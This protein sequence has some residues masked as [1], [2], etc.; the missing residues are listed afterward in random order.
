MFEIADLDISRSRRYIADGI[1]VLITR[2]GYVLYP[3]GGDKLKA[4]EIQYK[5]LGVGV[6]EIPKE[7]Y[8]RLKEEILSEEE[9]EPEVETPEGELDD[10]GIAVFLRS[11]LEEAVSEEASDIHIL[12]REKSYEIKFRINGILFSRRKVS[13]PVGERLVNKVKTVANMDIANSLIPQDSKFS[14][15][16][17]GQDVEVRVSTS[18]TVLGER[19]VL[20]IQRKTNVLAY[21]FEDLGLG[22]KILEEYLEDLHKP[23]GMILN[24]GPTGQGKTT[25]FYV[26]IVH[27]LKAFGESRSVVTIEDPV[28]IRIPGIDQIEVD[29]GVGRTF[30]G[31][32]RSLLRQDPDVILVGE[33]RDEETA[34]LAVRASMTGHLVLATLH[35]IDSVNAIP[36][37]KDLGI[38]SINLAS[39]LNGV[40]SQRLVRK[41]CRNC[42]REVPVPKQ[43]REKYSIP[44]DVYLKGEGCEECGYTG[45]K[46][47]TAVFEYLKVDEE[48]KWMISEG[49]SEL[50]IR[51]RLRK[52]DFLSLWDNALLLVRK[53]VTSLEEVLTEIPRFGTSRVFSLSVREFFYPKKKVPVLVGNWKGY[54]F[55]RASGGISVIF[56]EPVPLE[57][58]REIPLKLEGKTYTF[59]PT[60][61]GYFDGKLLVG[62]RLK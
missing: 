11:L 62:G 36:R 55:D 30:S 2:D 7:D 8:E 19:A 41:V 50:E 29:E 52:R 49:F 35:A 9:P 40:L 58:F 48:V 21:S 43:I 31:V 38:S 10:T 51:E 32:L 24:V 37:M 42:A 39:V 28:E 54:V 16:I 56:E 34:S 25:T 5:E 23:F 27:L 44:F 20:R 14:V 3:E 15:R 18:P 4:L 1:D 33:I 6:K 60:S 22:G 53:G 13:R 26:S 17:L 45:Y 61:Y 59:I 47:R 46:G 12:P 57:Y